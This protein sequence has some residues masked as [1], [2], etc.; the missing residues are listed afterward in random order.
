MSSTSTQPPSSPTDRRGRPHSRSGP[1][2]EGRG[3]EPVP[4]QEQTVGSWKLFQIL[5][6][7]LLNPGLML[8][9]GLAVSSG[10]TPSLAIGSVL[11]GIAIAFA[12]YT[13]L[14]TMGVDYGL[15]G[16]VATRAFVGIRASRFIVSTVR[17]ISAAFWFGV[18]TVAGS[19]GI[20]A[21]VH[22]LT[23]RQW[24]FTAVCIVFGAAQL[25]IAVLGYGSLA[26]LSRL[27][28]PVKLIGLPWIV[29]ALMGTKEQTLP[30][31]LAFNHGTTGQWLIFIAFANTVAITW[32]S[33]VTDAADYCRYTSSRR[34]MWWATGAAAVVGG[35]LSSAFGAFGAA[36]SSGHSG[37][38]FE[39]A[40]AASV[41]AAT[42]VVI[43]V[44]LVLENWTINVLNVY[45]GGL[46]LNNL[47]PRLGRSTCTIL[48][49]VAGIAVSIL[50]DLVD[51]FTTAISTG[52][53]VFG[54]LAAVIA[55]DYVVFKRMKINVDDLFRTSGP[56]WYRR[57][58]N[59]TALLWTG[60]GTAAY[61]LIPDAW[62]PV[63]P[64][65]LIAG[66]GYY[67]MHKLADPR[68]TRPHDERIPH[69]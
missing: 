19:A 61:F 6:N 17:T 49:G 8:I 64:A 47:F 2:V 51:K 21:A 45:T 38:T 69:A 36:W 28:F 30:A 44:V 40:G 50:P 32:L 18:Q 22:G 66:F 23:G 7:T 62:L 63:I 56:Y 29:I 59:L 10:L 60:L 52:G 20:V 54:P 16:A 27:A 48:V 58:V 12:L 1:V 46:A 65:M 55:V 41:G 57:G 13:L 3:I 31:V 9:G 34:K 35:A 33:Q 24:S 67:L 68:P 15:Q 42:L 11:L 5:V 26:W 4:P 53:A 25:L 14:A 39:V 43:L 37:N